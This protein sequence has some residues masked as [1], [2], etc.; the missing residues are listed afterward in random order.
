MANLI[1]SWY[2]ERTRRVILCSHYDTRP[3]ADQETRTGATGSSRSS[4]PTTAAPASPC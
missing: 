3:I 2:P 4:A 1:V